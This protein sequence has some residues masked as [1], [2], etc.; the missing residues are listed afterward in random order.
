MMFSFFQV[1]FN[2]FVTSPSIKYKKELLLIYSLLKFPMDNEVI[3]ILFFSM[4]S[5]AA[6]LFVSVFKRSTGIKKDVV[7]VLI[8]LLRLQVLSP[9]LTAHLYMKFHV[10]YVY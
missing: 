2:E 8:L 4:L 10:G 7:H 9:S 6:L 1:A 3:N 5:M